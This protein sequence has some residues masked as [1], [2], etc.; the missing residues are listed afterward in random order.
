MRE[1]RDVLEDRDA[2]TALFALEGV[3]VAPPGQPGLVPGEDHQG[4]G[5]RRQHR[6]RPERP[7][8]LGAERQ[9]DDQR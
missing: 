5:T 8:G 2:A 3:A 7:P 4:H 9:R 1:P 6:P